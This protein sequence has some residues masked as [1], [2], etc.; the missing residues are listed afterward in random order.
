[1][2]G[3]YKHIGNKKYPVKSYG[4]P[5]AK[6]A[7]VFPVLW[8]LLVITACSGE[9]NA[10]YYEEAKQVLHDQVLEEAERAKEMEPVT[11][12]SEISPRSAGWKND[13]YSEGDYWWPDPE[14]PDGP[15]IQKDGLTNPD[16]FVAHRK[17]MIRFSRII[18]A[19]ASAY[20]ITGEDDYVKYAVPHL[21]AWFADK[22]TRMSP[23]LK[24]A[25]AIQGRVTG[26]GIGIID[27][28]QL[29][30]VAR[31][32]QCME[33]SEMMDSDVLA[34]ARQWFADYLQ[35]LTTHPYGKEEM[36]KENNH[37][38]CWVMQA[39]C[40][41]SFTENEELLDFCRKRYKEI[42]L[43]GQ[44]AE[45]G[46]FPCEIGRTKAYGYSLFNLDAM[47]M[48]CLILSGSGDDLWHYQTPDGRS[49]RKG[50]EYLY[51]FVADKSRWYLEPDTMYW[52]E[53]P[54]AHPFLVFGAE[55]FRRKEWLDTWK[56]LDHNPRV[57]EVIRNLPVRHPLLWF[58]N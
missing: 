48:V 52:D 50:I 15:Y 30:E 54:V 31:G 1:M 13:F 57:D 36:G 51:P 23:H 45:D 40:F 46:S 32:M 7:R 22:K 39:A 14:N 53:W 27:G 17:A 38:T 5:V 20:K 10:D 9:K 43:P 6:S 42:L 4:G 21:R 19:L 18:G 35:W 11:V 28:I 26:R 12:T 3:L 47:V 16:N 25:Q 33:R 29:M 34:A 58:D 56:K 44:M 49:V 55:E 2:I 8:I 41:A 24:C 37:G